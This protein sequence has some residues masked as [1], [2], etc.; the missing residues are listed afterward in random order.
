MIKLTGSGTRMMAININGS[1]TC[2]FFSNAFTIMTDEG[3]TVLNG[4]TTCSLLTSTKFDSTT[5]GQSSYNGPG[6]LY[7]DS[8]NLVLATETESNIIEATRPNFPDVIEVVE[9]MIVT[10]TDKLILNIDNT[11]APDGSPEG[12]DDGIELT[13]AQCMNLVSGDGFVYQLRDL[14][15]FRGSKELVKFRNIDDIEMILEVKFQSLLCLNLSR[16]AISSDDFVSSAGYLCTGFSGLGMSRTAFFTDSDTVA[17]EIQEGIVTSHLSFTVSNNTAMISNRLSSPSGAQLQVINQGSQVVTLTRADQIEHT[18]DGEVVIMDEFGNVLRQFGSSGSPCS[19]A[20]FDNNKVSFTSVGPFSAPNL[21]DGGVE[22]VTSEVEG[23]CMVFAYTASNSFVKDRVNMLISN[24]TTTTPPP[25]V[26]FSTRTNEYGMVTLQANDKPLQTVSPGRSVSVGLTQC[27][28]YTNNQLSILNNCDGRSV[29]NRFDGISLVRT[30]GITNTITEFSGSATSPLPGGGQWFFSGD[31][32]FYTNSAGLTSFIQNS[33]NNAPSATVSTVGQEVNGE[34]EVSLRTGGT[35]FFMFGGVRDRDAIDVKGNQALLYSS[36]N[37]ASANIV[38]VPAGG[39]LEHLGGSPGMVRITGGTGSEIEPYNVSIGNSLFSADFPG[40]SDFQNVPP[41][42]TLPGGGILYIGS[43]GSLYTLDD[44]ANDRIYNT[45]SGLSGLN[46]LGSAPSLSFFDDR[47]VQMFNGS[48]PTALFGPGTLYSSNNSF[49]YTTSTQLISSLPSRVS[50][51]RPLGT[52][53]VS[54]TGT[55]DVDD[56]GVM[57]ATI[58]INSREIRVPSGGTVSLMFSGGNITVVSGGTERLEA[59]D[60]EMLTFFDG[61]VVSTVSGTDD[62]TFPGGGLLLV[63]ENMAFY[64]TEPSTINLISRAISG[65]KST[66]T[67]PNIPNTRPTT[68]ISKMNEVDAGFGQLVTVYS[69]STVNLR[70]TAGNANPPASFS[71]SQRN[72]TDNT[73]EFVS[74]METPNI[75]FIVNGPNDVTLQLTSVTP[76]EM[77]YRCEASNVLSTVSRSTRVSVLPGGEC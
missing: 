53:Y 70:C 10:R 35:N 20:Y 29:A 2:N 46:V 59:M 4:I 31:Q 11:N 37:I 38:R 48:S 22:V 58:P 5:S 42:T 9:Y 49:F 54:T 45:L 62:M 68:I 40:D 60:I 41:Q 52:N 24:I 14:T 50:R 76:S 63:D 65:A 47:L 18:G 73:S 19:L 61:L 32:G 44:R 13:G 1:V 34:I 51:L 75:M 27:S 77:E 71:F 64:V 39:S 56:G 26:F 74:L 57:V 21:P 67:G 72:A 43:V 15:V 28:S 25:P 8:T 23:N 3:T 6:V 36:N 30:S 12:S 33:I 55:I 7:I 16:H 66:F 17:R 69:G